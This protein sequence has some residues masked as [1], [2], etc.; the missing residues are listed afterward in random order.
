MSV[1]WVTKATLSSP[2]G[3]PA[4]ARRIV[5]SIGQGVDATRSRSPSS[6]E[7]KQV[8]YL[9][10]VLNGFPADQFSAAYLKF[11]GDDPRLDLTDLFVFAS[12][13]S[14]RPGT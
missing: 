11:P 4:Q 12:S 14:P 3:S 13:A 9:Q 10:Q 5:A 1:P 6:A 2:V 7:A 8:P